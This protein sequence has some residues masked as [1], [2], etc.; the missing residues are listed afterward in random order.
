MAIKSGSILALAICVFV[1]VVPTAFADSIPRLFW[2]PEN[3]PW[4][5]GSYGSENRIGMGWWLKDTM[6][7]GQ[8]KL[9]GTDHP[10]VISWKYWAYGD[11]W[12]GGG[13]SPWDRAQLE[14]KG[15]GMIEWVDPDF[16]IW[17]DSILLWTLDEISNGLSSPDSWGEFHVDPR[18]VHFTIQPGF[19]YTVFQYNWS[20]LNYFDLGYSGATVESSIELVPEPPVFLLLSTGFGV[21]GWL[22]WRRRGRNS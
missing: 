19:L 14:L 6:A 11:F 15:A 20:K 16:M 18:E 9:E 2:F 1:V 5:T 7:V 8:F 17:T 21:V 12:A 4:A 10:A 13:Y 22:A 3:H